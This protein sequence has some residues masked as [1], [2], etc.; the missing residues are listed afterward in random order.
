VVTGE[1]FAD[2]D[3]KAGN[4]VDKTMNCV[5]RNGDGAGKDTDDDVEIAEKKIGANK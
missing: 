4:G 5:G 1:F 2:Y 3:E